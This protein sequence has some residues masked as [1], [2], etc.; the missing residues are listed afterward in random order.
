MTTLFEKHQARFERA[1]QAC[2]TRHCWS[3]YPEMPDKYPEA[4]HAKSA[5]LVAF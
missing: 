1:Q 4:V 2:A 3:P 5:G